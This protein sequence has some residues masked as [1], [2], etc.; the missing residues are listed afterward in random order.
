[1]ICTPS[2]ALCQAPVGQKA[3]NSIHQINHY[4]D[5]VCFVLLTLFCWIAIYPVDGV[6]QP[7]NNRAQ[8][9]IDV[10]RV[11]YVILVGGQT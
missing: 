6:I 8:E 11:S 2:C 9:L 3:D 10:C 1:M 7:L 5:V 4:S